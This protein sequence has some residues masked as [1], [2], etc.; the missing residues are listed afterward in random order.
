MNGT[1]AGSALGTVV[2]GVE[3]SSSARAA[4]T[5]AAAEAARR[6]RG[7]YLVH[8]TDVESH[9]PMLSRDETARLERAGREILDQAAEAVAARHPELTV[10]K[11]LARGAPSA[12]LRHVAALSGTIVVGHRG[13][14]GFS[15]LLLGSVGLE[16]VANASTPVVVVR[17]ATEGAE[18]GAVLAAVRDEEDLGCAR[19]AAREALLRKVPLRLLHVWNG[20]QPSGARA[21]PRNGAGK[22]ARERTLPLPGVVDRIREEFP[23]LT[24]Y[25]DGEKS[26]SVPGTLVAA[27]C[28]AGLLVVGGRRAS[29]YVGPALGRTT[30]G[31]VQHAHCPVELIPRH[32]RAQGLGHGSTS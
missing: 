27:S 6:G 4:V 28:H 10:I 15:S 29:G 26:R 24:V 1:T 18:T 25:A 7:L 5:W 22:L 21:G 32:G 12:A 14:G 3:G 11:E 8:A 30:L 2:V 9:A 13:R 23:E 16:T 17:G 31:L 20:V 19:V